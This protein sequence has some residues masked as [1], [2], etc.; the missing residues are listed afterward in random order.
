MA[1]CARVIFLTEHIAA[2]IRP[3]CGDMPEAE[4]QRLAE[5]MARVEHKYTSEPFP[6]YEPPTALPA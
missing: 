6:R 2:R 4:L 5:N 3:S 1:N